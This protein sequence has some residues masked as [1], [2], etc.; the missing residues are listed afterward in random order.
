MRLSR[1]SS[2]VGG[3]GA[4]TASDLFRMH[5]D[6]A[7][8]TPNFVMMQMCYEVDG[9]KVFKIMRQIIAVEN[10]T[11]GTVLATALVQILSAG[12]CRREANCS[13]G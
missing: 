1:A 5:S 6:A 4:V 2:A 10:R 3:R 8:R 7:W 9:I 11:H 12:N 13:S